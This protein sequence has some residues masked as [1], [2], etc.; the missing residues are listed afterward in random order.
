MRLTVIVSAEFCDQAGLG[1]KFVE[2]LQG[3]GPL[4]GRLV[5]VQEL[6][7]QGEE[8]LTL[9]DQEAVILLHEHTN[10]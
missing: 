8:N 5:R 6:D 7:D 4:P 10:Q 9:G 3:Q 2:Q 1:D